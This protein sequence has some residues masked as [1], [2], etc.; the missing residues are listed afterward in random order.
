MNTLERSEWLVY[1]QIVPQYF[2]KHHQRIL[3]I[4]D[5]SETEDQYKNMTLNDLLRN[6]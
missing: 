2:S 1:Q 4:L 6:T 5:G 3:A